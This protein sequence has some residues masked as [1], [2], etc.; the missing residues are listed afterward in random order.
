M[1][2]N[3]FWFQALNCEICMKFSRQYIA[4][5]NNDCLFLKEKASSPED[6]E[7]CNWKIAAVFTLA[8]LV[9]LYSWLKP[10]GPYLTVITS[11]AESSATAM[12]IIERADGAFV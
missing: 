12:M 9:P 10:T 8:F 2:F 11:P 4:M 1:K 6:G 5:D 3:L 7:L